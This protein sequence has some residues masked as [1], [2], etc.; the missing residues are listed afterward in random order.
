MSE[1][2]RGHLWDKIIIKLFASSWY[3]FLTYIYDARSHLYQTVKTMLKKVES[4]SVRGMK[5]Y[6]DSRG[7]APSIL[8]HDNIQEWP[9][10]NPTCFVPSVQYTGGWVDLR[11]RLDISE[12][13]KQRRGRFF[14]SP[15]GSDWLWGP[16]SPLFNGYSGFFPSLW[17]WPLTSI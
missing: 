17:S 13:M 3:I 12:M 1:T 8:N 7:I 14:S 9:P 2:C 5:A 10:S 11:T 6:R 4:F 15:T 16:P